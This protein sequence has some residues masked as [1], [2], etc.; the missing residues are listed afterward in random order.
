MLGHRHRSLKIPRRPGAKTSE[1]RWWNKRFLL[2]TWFS[3]FKM[4]FSNA[5]WKHWKPITENRQY[6]DWCDYISTSTEALENIP[7]ESFQQVLKG[8]GRSLE[9]T[10]KWVELWGLGGWWARALQRLCLWDFSWKLKKMWHK[11]CSAVFWPRSCVHS[12]SSLRVCGWIKR[13]R[14]ILAYR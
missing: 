13:R 8:G 9:R 10:V 1:T 12:V 11:S 2:L 3:S 4:I 14:G 6:Q 5:L 7:W